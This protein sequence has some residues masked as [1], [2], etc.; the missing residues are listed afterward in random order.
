MCAK[1]KDL[2]PPAS[3]GGGEILRWQNRRQ[4]DGKP[5]A[6]SHQQKGIFRFSMHLGARL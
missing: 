4:I 1:G 3:R 2:G 5:T 6:T